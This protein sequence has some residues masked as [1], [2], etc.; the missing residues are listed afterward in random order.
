MLTRRVCVCGGGGGSPKLKKNQ[1]TR[2]VSDL[3]IFILFF[4]VVCNLPSPQLFDFFLL[5][6]AFLCFHMLHFIDQHT[7]S[8]EFVFK[9]I[10]FVRIVYLQIKCM[11]MMNMAHSEIT[12]FGM[13]G[14]LVPIHWIERDAFNTIWVFGSHSLPFYFFFISFAILLV[15]AY[16]LPY[17]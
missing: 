15:Q 10:G 6:S 16:Y 2:S 4:F 9:A 8:I 17:R 3:L 14:D 5:L 7:N 13:H 11:G 1:L 12:A